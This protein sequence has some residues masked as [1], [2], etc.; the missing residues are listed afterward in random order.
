[1][2]C[3]GES[4]LARAGEYGVLMG[5]SGGFGKGR[6]MGGGGDGRG[7]GRKVEK[8]GYVYDRGRRG[9]GGGKV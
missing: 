5:G 3:A 8:E 6:G 2:T 1:M 9:E 7:L 4:T